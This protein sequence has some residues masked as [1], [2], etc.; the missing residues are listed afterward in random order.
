MSDN[1]RKSPLSFARFLMKQ[2]MPIRQSLAFLSFLLLTAALGDRAWGAEDVALGQGLA[3]ARPNAVAF[4][5]FRHGLFVHLVYG[6]TARPDATKH[7]TLDE[8]AGAFDVNT[9]A[10]Q[11]AGMGVEYVFL[12]AWHKAMYQ[13][14]PNP[15]L[16][17]WLPGHTSKRDLIGEIADAFQAR[18]IKLVLY[19]HPND[20]HDL[21]KDEQNRVG[22]IGLPQDDPNRN[23]VLNDF[24]NEVFTDFCRQYAGKPNVVG[25][26]WDSWIHKGA[27]ID[28]WRLNKTVRGI[29]PDAVLMSNNFDFR[30]KPNFIDLFS[31]ESRGPKTGALHEL[32]ALHYN[33]SF[34]I[35]QN[36]W[37]H[38]KA[39]I[40]LSPESMYRFLVLTVGTGAPGGVAWAVSPLAD[41]KTWGADNQ[42]LQ[43]MHDLN[44]HIARV[45]PSLCGVMP[46]RNWLLPTKTTW[47]TAPSFA[48]ARSVD[49]AT[50]YIHVIK[51]P[52]GRTLELPLA[53]ER[54]S[55]GRMLIGKKAVALETTA[56]GLRITLPEGEQWDPLDTVIELMIAR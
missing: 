48:A 44:Q 49:G 47:A 34:P 51:P 46:S 7:A 17:R 6:I 52:V 42:P 26:W 41:G 19:A 38:P 12:T 43:V 22:Y 50:E 56:S 54:F 29:M 8:F 13:L 9:F 14:G 15:A 24:I 10:D 21:S 4:R 1:V 53:N 20:G 16:E 25:I 18:G 40:K 30:Q 37:A 27:R 23:K 55:S 45:R 11:V 36:W 33:Q 32:T 3:D 28:M 2:T 5:Q 35:A 39:T 31:I